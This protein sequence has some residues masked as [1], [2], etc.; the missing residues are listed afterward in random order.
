M[1]NRTVPSSIY[2]VTVQGRLDGIYAFSAEREA[3]RFVDAVVEAGSE[4]VCTVVPLNITPDHTDDLI[5]A[6][7]EA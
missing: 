6:E 3:D 2:V 1:T 4:A 5:A 7:R